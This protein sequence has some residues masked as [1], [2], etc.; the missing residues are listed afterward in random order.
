[1]RA[2]GE[3]G[4]AAPPIRHQ[5]LAAGFLLDTGARRGGLHRAQLHRF[6]EGFHGIAHGNERVRE[7][8]IEFQV[9]DGIRDHAPLQL[10][11]GHMGETLPF[12]LQRLDVMP[13]A[14]TRIEPPISSC[15]RENLHC[16]C[17]GFN[18]APTFPY[19]SMAQARAFLVHRR[20]A[21]PT[22]N[23]RHEQPR[24]TEAV[25]QLAAPAC[26][27][28]AQ[29]AGRRAE[30]AKLV[31]RGGRWGPRQQ[32]DKPVRRPRRTAPTAIFRWTRERGN[33]RRARRVEQSSH[34]MGRRLAREFPE[35]RPR[36]HAS[37]PCLVE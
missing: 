28:A 2:F 25:H 34:A 20:S 11:V 35:A 18:F 4:F 8:A 22:G 33:P 7:K 30:T 21:S 1:V 32:S 15:L 17:S 29:R 31:R 5:L 19:A 14:M 10:V 12:L 27:A 24:E 16:T 36:S 13:L 6:G 9:G 3:S 37:P 26:C 23:G